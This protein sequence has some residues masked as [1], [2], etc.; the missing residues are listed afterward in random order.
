MTLFKCQ[1]SILLRF[2]KFIA[3][4]K[5]K[6]IQLTFAQKLRLMEYFDDHNVT[7]IDQKY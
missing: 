5:S 2:L 1:T 3:T 4:P 7:P 6:S